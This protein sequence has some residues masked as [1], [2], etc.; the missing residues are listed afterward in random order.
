ME[1]SAKRGEKVCFQ[2]LVRPS[3]EQSEA[4]RAN[5]LVHTLITHFD[6]GLASICY[7]NQAQWVIPT[8]KDNIVSKRASLTPLTILEASTKKA[9]TQNDDVLVILDT[10]FKHIFCDQAT[11]QLTVRAIHE[12]DPLPLV[13]RELLN[14]QI[15][16]P[17]D[18]SFVYIT[19]VKW[20]ISK[21]MQAVKYCHRSNNVCAVT[22]MV[23]D[24]VDIY[25]R[26]YGCKTSEYAALAMFD[27]NRLLLSLDTNDAIHRNVHSPYGIDC[28]TDTANRKRLLPL[29]HM[30]EGFIK[31]MLENPDNNKNFTKG[32]A[33]SWSKYIKSASRFWVFFSQPCHAP[34]L[35]LAM[36]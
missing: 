22:V 24:R 26:C 12:K 16:K 30:T 19:E 34:S 32:L 6:G 23:D 15:V 4:D 5:E 2:N 11:T 36:T 17:S 31:Q 21:L 35:P 3:P 13:V 29:F 1:L 9:K 27:K 20:C 25:A 14:R 7:K 28:V 18:V 8:T 33:Y 10:Y